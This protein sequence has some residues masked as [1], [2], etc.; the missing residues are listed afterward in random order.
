MPNSY[1]L[2]IAVISEDAFFLKQLTEQIQ[3]NYEKLNFE[4]AICED[5]K[6][7]LNEMFLVRPHIILAPQKNLGLSA[8]EFERQVQRETTQ[9]SIIFFGIEKESPI[10]SPHFAWPLVE[11]G[12]FFA[13]FL[14]FIPEEFKQKAGLIRRTALSEKLSTYGEQYRKELVDSEASRKFIGLIPVLLVANA[15][16][17]VS[18]LKTEISFQKNITYEVKTPKW[19]IFFEMGLCSVLTILTV[20]LFFYSEE[21]LLFWSVFFLASI[22]SLSLILGRFY[23]PFELIEQKK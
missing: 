3:S 5:G 17:S 4:F 12:S 21:R 14:N 13:K 6:K 20:F 1:K 11:W 9:T 18:S 22:S 19:W 16:Q 2:K 23:N 7:F 15:N 10:G 8:E